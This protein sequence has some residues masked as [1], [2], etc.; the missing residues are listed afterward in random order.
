MEDLNAVTL[1]GK[2]W[3]TLKEIKNGKI[4]PATGDAIASQ[5]REILRTT[6]TQLQIINHAKLSV[7]K[8]MIEFAKPGDPS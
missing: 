7:S 6:K 2:L 1:K 8:E 3:D 4:E 5:A